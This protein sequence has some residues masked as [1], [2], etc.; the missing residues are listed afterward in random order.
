MLPDTRN[1]D[2]VCRARRESCF[3]LGLAV[4]RVRETAFAVQRRLRLSLALWPTHASRIGG[5][6]QSLITEMAEAPPKLNFAAAASQAKEEVPLRL[7]E[8]DGQVVLRIV[9]HCREAQPS[10]V[11]GQLLGLDIGSTLEVT[12]AFPFPVRYQMWT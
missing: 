2:D 6:R 1:G 4:R 5:L 11:T 7:V 3:R 9:K 8:V 12:S 10:L